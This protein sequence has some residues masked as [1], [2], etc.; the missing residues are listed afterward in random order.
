MKGLNFGKKIVGVF[1]DNGIV[2]GSITLLIPMNISWLVKIIGE[3]SG[4][5]TVYFFCNNP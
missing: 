5:W 1:Y 4:K 2:N 3:L